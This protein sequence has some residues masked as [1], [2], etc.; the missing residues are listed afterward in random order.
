MLSNAVG[1]RRLSHPAASM[2]AMIEVPPASVLPR[3]MTV[4]EQLLREVEQAPDALLEA[5]N[6]WC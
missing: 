1:D 2:I 6:R 4:K 5:A 3:S